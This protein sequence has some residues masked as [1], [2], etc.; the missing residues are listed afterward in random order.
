[1]DR[2]V[3]LILIKINPLSPELN[4]VILKT[5]MQL[6]HFAMQAPIFPYPEMI[7]SH[8][9]SKGKT[10]IFQINNSINNLFEEFLAQLGVQP[11]SSRQ[12]P[13]MFLHI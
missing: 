6:H 8:K 1:M 13:C 11:Q 3:R 9:I 5:T 7:K 12:H 4:G 2:I 10:L